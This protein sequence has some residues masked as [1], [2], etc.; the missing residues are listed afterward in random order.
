MH[1]YRKLTIY[2]SLR[3]RDP[4][5][6][7][8]NKLKKLAREGLDNCIYSHLGHKFSKSIEVDFFWM[9]KTFWIINLAHLWKSS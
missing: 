8:Q 4:N 1:I 6:K 5:F 2:V 9:I 7:N 3:P